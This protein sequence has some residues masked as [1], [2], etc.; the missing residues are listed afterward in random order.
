MRGCA[1]V[2]PPAEIQFSGAVVELSLMRAGIIRMLAAQVC[3]DRERTFV[4][5]LRFELANLIES[6]Q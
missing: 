5:L 2:V 6:R 3:E 4:I 1:Q